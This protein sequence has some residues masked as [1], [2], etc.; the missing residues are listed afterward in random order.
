MSAANTESVLGIAVRDIGR[1]RRV[2]AVV[3]RHGF[4][5]F[6][7]RSPLA[8]RFGGEGEEGEAQDSAPVRFR[9]LL[10]ELGPTWIKLGQILSTRHDLLPRDYIEALGELQDNTPSLP[11]A[12]IKAAVVDNAGPQT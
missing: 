7:A 3:T 1:L 8:G 11:F 12:Q 4:G 5:E 6:L 9:R 2:A 10:E